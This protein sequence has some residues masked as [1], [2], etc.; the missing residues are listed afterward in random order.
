VHG[1]ERTYVCAP[2]VRII[3]DRR[4]QLADVLRGCVDRVAVMEAGG[5]H[6]R[7]AG[8]DQLAAERLEQALEIAMRI[9]AAHA[10]LQ[11][12]PRRSRPRRLRLR[13]LSYSRSDMA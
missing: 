11:T 3:D 5:A 6:L 7:L 9:P 12:S 1:L 13:V 10:S 4:D 8:V 2:L